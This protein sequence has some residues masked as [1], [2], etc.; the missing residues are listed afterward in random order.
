[1]VQGMRAKLQLRK[2]E[3]T[4]FSQPT[5]DFLKAHM[6]LDPLQDI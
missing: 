3:I 4:N 2:K 6:K 5:I 1:M